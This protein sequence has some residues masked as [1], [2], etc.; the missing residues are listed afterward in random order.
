[1]KKLIIIIAIIVSLFIVAFAN[2]PEF[3]YTLG[4]DYVDF[5]EDTKL[6]YVRGMIDMLYTAMEFYEPEIYESMVDKLEFV[7]VDQFTLAFNKYLE[8]H[9]ECLYYPATYSFML[10]VFGK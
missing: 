3:T 6:T 1:M 7:T 10:T 2:Y 4:Y 5:R 9:P 8:E